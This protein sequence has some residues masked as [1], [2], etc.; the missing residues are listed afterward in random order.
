[1]VIRLMLVVGEDVFAGV[2]PVQ[3]ASACTNPDHPG[4]VFQ[5]GGHVILAEGVRVI[6]D[7]FIGNNL[8]A[9]ITRQPSRGAKPHK[10][11]AVLKHGHDTIGGEAVVGR[12]VPEA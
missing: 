9:V 8:V 10:A 1:M 4:R 12:Q 3:P 5:Q 7:V 6:R 2:E 11:A